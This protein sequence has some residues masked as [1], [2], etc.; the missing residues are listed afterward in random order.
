[1]TAEQERVAIKALIK[2][3]YVVEV[4]NPDAKAFSLKYSV[5]QRMLLAGWDRIADRKAVVVNDNGEV[6]GAQG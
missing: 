2:D 5:W 4:R 6:I 3:G 1:M